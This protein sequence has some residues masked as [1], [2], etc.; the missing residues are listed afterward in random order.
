MNLSVHNELP[1]LGIDYK[2]RGDELWLHHCPYCENDGTRTP[3]Q[4]FSINENSGEFHC[5]HASCDAGGNL[6]KLLRDF[7]LAAPILGARPKAYVRPK[8]RPEL[9][10]HADKFYTWYESERGVSQETLRK[11]GVGHHVQ[12]GKVFIVYQY[13]DRDGR[14]INRKFRAADKSKMWSERGAELG[15]YGAQFLTDNGPLVVCEGEDDAHVLASHGIEN[16]VSVPSGATSY[17]PAMDA[18][19]EAFDDIVVMFDNDDAGQRGAQAFADKAGITK[20]RNVFLPYKDARDCQKH[21]FRSFQFMAAIDNAEHFKCE[22]IVKAHDVEN[23]LEGYNVGVSTPCKAFNKVL[24]GLR[25]KETTV[26]IGHTGNGK[27]TFALNLAA[28][29]EHVNLPT[30]VCCFENRLPAVARKCVEIRS[31]KPIFDYDSVLDQWVRV[32]SNEWIEE[33]M[34]LLGASKLYFLNKTTKNHGYYTIDEVERVIRYGVKFHGVKL[35]VLDHLHYF[36]RLSDSR[37]P[38]LKIDESMRRLHVLAEELDVHLAIITHPH[39]IEDSRTGK[40]AKLGLM[41]TKGASSI[42]QE[43]DNYI[44][45][46]RGTGENLGKALIEIQKNR[47]LG[48]TGQVTFDVLPNNNTFLPE[49]WKGEGKRIFVDSAD[50]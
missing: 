34:Q 24:G 13:R 35:V 23:I 48:R 40:P 38:V 8:E 41:S 9:T 27:T 37:N 21:G 45:V 30:L 47:E 14:L 29:A 2:Q 43:T 44:V 7:D 33:Q 15:Y 28:W 25:T 26:I 5:F 31:G 10:E 16:V 1:K 32:A 49:G 6:N 20:C 17:T 46:C 12:D 39:K 11:F 18:V 4:K 22:E 42:A 36:L 3:Y 19:N 50:L